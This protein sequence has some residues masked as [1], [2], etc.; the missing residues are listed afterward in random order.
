MS[1]WNQIDPT[2][3]AF[4][5]RIAEEEDH[6]L[7]PMWIQRYYTQGGQPWP[8]LVVTVS[9]R[10]RTKGHYHFNVGGSIKRSEEAWYEET[11]GIPAA[12]LPDVKEMFDECYTAIGVKT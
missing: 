4:L 5:V 8:L 10:E 7:G 2:T 9:A 6:D 1:K 11:H 3:H 12:L